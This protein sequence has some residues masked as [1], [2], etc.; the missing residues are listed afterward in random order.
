M[1]ITC[2]KLPKVFVSI[3]LFSMFILISWL[4]GDWK[5]IWSNV[6]KA[7]DNPFFLLG[8]M[9]LYF[10]AFIAR[11]YA[12][13]IYLRNKPTLSSCMAGI[14]YSLLLNHLLPFKIGDIA[15]AGVMGVREKD[16]AAGEILNSVIFLRVTDMLFLS[17]FS[18][19]GLIL[20][21][22]PYKILPFVLLSTAF[23]AVMTVG[24]KYVKALDRQWQMVKAALSGRNGWNILMLILISWLLES[25][26]IFGIM[27]VIGASITVPEAVWVNSV[28]V[29]G[30]VFQATPGGIGTYEAVMVFALTIS[31]SGPSTAYS[32]AIITHSLKFL[33][34]FAAGA[35]VIA[36]FPVSIPTLKKWMKEGGE[37]REKRFKI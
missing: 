18:L 24:K 8:L 30:Q 3:L 6:L 15:R 34:S 19:A 7:A 26:M 22:I 31:G 21:D 12:W 2:K 35:Y 25:S 37:N 27:E 1:Q 32:A 4:Y 9:M 5:E 11:G 17:A 20:F 28:T 16:I 23:F 33:F 13:K 29:A 10:A 14:F 36:N